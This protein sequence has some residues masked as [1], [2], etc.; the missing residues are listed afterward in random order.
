MN[1]IQSLHS[2]FGTSRATMIMIVV[3]FIV[4]TAPAIQAQSGPSVSSA[5][6][7]LH[8]RVVANT[9]NFY[10]YQDQ[11]SGL[12]H[13]FPSGFF[14]TISAITVDTGCIDDPA[15]SV[16]GCYPSSNNTALNLTHGT[17]FRVTFAVL[18]GDQYAGINIEEPLNW[19][20]AGQPASNGYD[21]T[22]ATAVSLDVR[23]PA[24]ISVQFGVNDCMTS[25]IQLPA[26]T[27][28][29]T[30]TF[31]LDTTSLSCTPDLRSVHLLFTVTT[32]AF[33]GSAGGTVLMD[34]IRFT[35]APPRAVQGSE[36]LSLPL[37]TQT[38]GVVPQFQIPFPPDQ[39]NR[40]ISS[41]YEA[42][43]S[44]LGLL[45]R[46][47]SQDLSDAQSIADAL[48]Y[49]LHNDNQGD[50]LPVAPGGF[51]GLHNAYSSGDIALLNG[52][53]TGALT[54][55]VRLAGFT[56]GS[57][58]PTGYCLVLDGATGGNNAFAVL[59]LIAAYREFGNVTYLNDALE[60]ANWIV[61]N[62]LDPT[63][64]GYGGYYYG[65]PDMGLPKV[66]Q[67]NK[68][69]ENNADIFAAFSAL[70]AVESQL[71]NPGAASMWTTNAQIAG[72]FVMAMYDS[73]NGRFYNG[74]VP[75]GTAS[76]PGVCPTGPQ[77]GNDVISV[78]DLLDSN[79]FTTL[80]MAGSGTYQNSIDWNQPINYA[81]S[82]YP[83][84][85]SANG[86][87][88]QGVDIISPPPAGIAWEFTGQLVETCHYIVALL[89]TSACG[90]LAQ[91]VL[92]QIGQVQASAPFADGIGVVAATINGENSPPSNLP[93][94]NECLATPFQCIPER[95]GLAATVWAILASEN[96]NVFLPF[97]GA[98]FSPSSRTFTGQQVG[99]TSAAQAVT[100]SNAGNV[101]LAISS[102]VVTGADPSDFEATNTCAANLAAG[103]N[104]TISV[105]F[106][107]TAVGTRTGS[108]TISD[109]ALNSPQTVSLTGT[110]TGP[111][112]GLSAPLTFPSEPVGTTSPPQTVTLTNTGNT[113][114]TFTAIGV[115]GPFAIVP[116]GTTCSAASS[117]P[118]SGSCTVALTFNPTAIG[119]A[120]GSI[121]F[122]DNASG[123]PQTVSLTGT[124]TGPTVSLPA[125]PTFPSEPVGTTSPSRTVALTNTGNAS[126]IFTAIDVAGPFA[127]AT[128]GTTC[129][130][131]SPVAASG[132]CTVAIIFT[133]TAA[134]TT[135]G[136]LSFSD[137]ALNSPQSLALSGTGQDFTMAASSGSPTSAT[138]A[139]GGTATYKLT[140]TALDGFG[141]AVNFICSGAPSDAP[142]QLSA[143]SLTPSSSGATLT[144]S[145]TTVAPSVSVPRPRHLPPVSPL[146]GLRGPLMLALVLAAMAWT[147]GRRNQPSGSRLKSAM[148]PLAAGLLLTLALAGCGGE[149][150]GGGTTHNPGTPVGTYTLTVTGSTGSGSSALS[151]S[152][153]LTLTV[154]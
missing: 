90:T 76:G 38:F 20:A 45:A 4:S 13:G 134:G 124:G 42:A 130:T 154:S 83:Q 111:I 115:S 50:L 70:A 26:S 12:N 72:N 153:T 128:S 138:V 147:I 19:G 91:T 30:K 146:S 117:V 129:S 1:P 48:D 82:V 35:P 104:C 78:C 49:A 63:G 120:S 116:S 64:S 62:L 106:T 123:S 135:A 52:Q 77:K 74:T 142:C 40:N 150:G 57:A 97:P 37:S 32:N 61:G 71:G 29:T 41:T 7:E 105:T 51:A 54:G 85:I 34:N 148:V 88:F 2:R 137:N 56:C 66:L 127:I 16:T 102:I 65:Y 107:P 73:A 68:S 67:T 21:L 133:P 33:E 75:T 110:G 99:T 119:M 27:T 92:T 143:N 3:L 9:N 28:Y 96:L 149:G 151:H 84:T 141:Q 114:L 139:P 131:S 43:L 132:S 126:L 60:I 24:G 47:T 23:S 125:P 17:V 109:N 36:T 15:D 122:T 14:G 145:V 5:Y 59:S 95:V 136:S 31:S 101:S 18:S 89:A 22:G 46:G 121:S 53:S 25:F 55:N 86:S 39:V 152:V 58:S 144:V 140:I 112:V 81:S 6:Q 8:Q 93:P 87:S 69:G 10:V 11:D 103:S 98:S 108:L 79:T 113:N 100:L 80:A 118:A 94:L 44:L